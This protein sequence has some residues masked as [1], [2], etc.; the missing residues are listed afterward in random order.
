MNVDPV[1]FICA[2]TQIN[3]PSA[4]PEISL[5]LA[6]E[7]TS[8]WQKTEKLLKQQNLAPPFWAFAWP[9]GQGLARYLLDNPSV[10]FGRKVVDFAAGSG[11]GAIAAM[12][13]GAKSAVAVDIDP[14]ALASIKINAQINSVDVTPCGGLNLEKIPARVDLILAGDVCYQ[15]AM[16]TAV[17]R[18]LRLC[19]EAGIEVLLSDPGRAYVPEKGKICLA[20]YDVPT[21]RE[22]EDKEVRTATIWKLGRIEPEEMD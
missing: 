12:K 8:L 6:S 19:V 3:S 20:R 21:S 18:W 2:H 9:G 1:E 16:S 14:L 10:V 15:Q 11:L 13:A 22:L 7:V 5:Y 17:L 4:V